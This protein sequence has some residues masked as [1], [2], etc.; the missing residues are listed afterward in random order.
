MEDI[1]DTIANSP[2]IASALAAV[3][4]EATP[5][6]AELRHGSKYVSVHQDSAGSTLNTTSIATSATDM[7]VLQPEIAE[8]CEIVLDS[9]LIGLLEGT[10]C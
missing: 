1:L 4:P 2:Q 7:L 6:L 10:V 3:Q 9:A 5:T 8:L